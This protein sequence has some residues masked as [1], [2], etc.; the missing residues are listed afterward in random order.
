MKRFT[1]TLAALLAA[2]AFA[3]DQ[4]AQPQQNLVRVALAAD[5]PRP[6]AAALIELERR[7]NVA[8]SYEDA[9]IVFAGEMKDVTNEVRRDLHRFAPGAA[10]KVIIPLGGTFTIFYDVSVADGRPGSIR[11]V[12][13]SAVDAHAAADLAGRHRVIET[14]AGFCVVPEAHHDVNDQLANV[15][16]V[17][18]ATITIAPGTRNG[19]EA[20]D[21]I[22]RAVSIASGSAVTIG[23]APATLLGRLTTTIS[24]KNEPARDV[25][26][27][28]LSE[29]NA[30]V[31]WQLFHDPADDFYALNLH[32]I[33]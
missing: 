22:C 26:A 10:P 13:Q 33:E 5:D 6:L 19:I 17:L 1:L 3:A 18:D 29:C 15:A 28:L 31:S 23:A 4:P 14:A 27:R 20:V 9:P 32:T 2:P 24:A 8:I 25:L 16:P 7:H 12:I 11:D 21:E 30:A